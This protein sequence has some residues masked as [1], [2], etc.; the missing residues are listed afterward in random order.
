ME[1]P[2]A[3]PAWASTCAFSLTSPQ[4]SNLRF[5]LPLFSHA[6]PSP[7]NAI[8]FPPSQILAYSLLESQRR[9]CLPKEHSR[10]PS[11]TVHGTQ[12]Q[13]SCLGVCMCVPVRL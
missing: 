5:L 13:N 3:S 7:T 1:L 9:E 8:S 6:A 12:S 2:G 11:I 4:S 10:D